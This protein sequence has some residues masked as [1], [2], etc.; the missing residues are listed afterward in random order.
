MILVLLE[1]HQLIKIL[2]IKKINILSIFKY[3]FCGHITD[4]KALSDYFKIV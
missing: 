2:N 4:H 1:K 3:F